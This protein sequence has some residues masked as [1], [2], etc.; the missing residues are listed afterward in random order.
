MKDTDYS[1]RALLGRWLSV[2]STQKDGSTWP[3]TMGATQRIPLPNHKIGSRTTGYVTLRN[4]TACQGTRL[5]ITV[6]TYAIGN[7]G[8]DMVVTSHDGAPGGFTL[9]QE[10]KLTRSVRPHL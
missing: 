10:D 9:A 6:L 7:L 4:H 8:G 3:T 2:A 1:S 5:R